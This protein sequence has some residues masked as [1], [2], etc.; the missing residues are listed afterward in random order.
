MMKKQKSI[1]DYNALEFHV[2]ISKE[3]IDN[4]V[5]SSVNKLVRFTKRIRRCKDQYTSK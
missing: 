5:T 3:H 2:Y 1:I 4:N